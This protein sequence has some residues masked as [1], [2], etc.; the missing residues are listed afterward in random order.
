VAFLSQRLDDGTAVRTRAR[1]LS[2]VRRFHIYLLEEE[3][4]PGNPTELMEPMKLPFHYPSVLSEEEMER[5]LEAPTGESPEAV[6]DRALLEF[7]Y[8]TGARV[9]ELCGLNLG[10]LH[11]A[12]ELVFIR[13]KGGKQRL[14]PVSRPA[15]EKILV[16]LASARNELLKSASRL[17][18]E[19]R[20]RLFVS[21]RGRGL[22]RQAVWKLIRKYAQTAGLKEDLHPHMVRHC[23]AT[24][25]LVRGADLRVVQTLLGHSDIS[26]TEIYTHLSQENL[27]RSFDS[28]HPR[29]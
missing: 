29:A 16:Y 2:A 10:D 8:A 21:R 27:R 26:T 5:L 6:R 12:E 28:F 25:L 22:T 1:Q 9:S 3:Q 7:L 13:G 11:L 4:A 19:S 14:V 24:H 18:P 23:F 17:L 20:T 15:R